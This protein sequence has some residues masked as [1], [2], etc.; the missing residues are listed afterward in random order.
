MTDLYLKKNKIIFRIIHLN[1]NY[2]LANY[3]HLIDWGGGNCM[4]I[5]VLNKIS[6][7]MKFHNKNYKDYLTFTSSNHPQNCLKEFSKFTNGII[8]LQGICLTILG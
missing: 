3:S 7:Y 5:F 8:G 6:Y 4:V 1:I 2:S